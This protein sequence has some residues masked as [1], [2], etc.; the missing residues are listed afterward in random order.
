MGCA[1]PVRILVLT[2]LFPS[3]WD[4]LRASFNRQQFDRLGARHDVVV[5]TAIDF[6][7][8]RRGRRGDPPSL[9]HAT[10]DDFTFW[11]PPRIGRSLHG[12]TWYASLLAQQG[13]R[14]RAGRYDLLLASWA[15][16]DAVGT[17]WLARRLGLPYV[18]KVHGSDLNVTTD[19]RLRRWQISRAL[20]DAGAVVAV[21]QAL[22]TKARE[23]GVP[24]ER[25]RVIY[26]GVDG[27][28][29]RPG[30]RAEARSA[31]ALPVDAP[32]V[33]YVGNLKLTKGCMDLL[34]SF[35]A[36]LARNPGARLV[37]VGSG[38]AHAGLVQR[39]RQLGIETNVLFAGAAAHAQLPRW[40]QAADVLALPSHAEG[41]PN[42]VLEAMACGLPVV[43]TAVGGIPEVL[44]PTAGVQVPAH[45]IGAISGALNEAL[46]RTWD[47]E[48]ILSHA[49]NFR[50][51]DNI[52][53]LD[54]V[55]RQVATSRSR[56]PP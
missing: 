51:D 14:L 11:Y 33:L 18:V 30:D 53:Q 6:R 19:F 9:L 44:P 43:A 36:V 8:R 41:V 34:D 32:V 16:P 55:L 54:A 46:A 42:V 49:C 56:M 35:P 17:R 47:R 20:R 22:A 3:A 7:D 52:D 39:S 25:V 24:G 26:N 12:A 27:E 15:F 23:L 45:D 13:R 31:L 40:M 1:E 10:A 4:P 28:L 38:G 50:W 5:M 29:F 2:N 21:S 48:A 37:F